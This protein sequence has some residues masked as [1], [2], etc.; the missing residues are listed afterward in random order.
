MSTPRRWE[1][2]PRLSE[3]H[4]ARFPELPRLLVQLLHNRGICDPQ[5]VARFLERQP[6]SDTDPFLL[7]GMHQAVERL[8]AAI[9]A[10]ER[11]VFRAGLRP[12]RTRRRNDQRR[13]CHWPR[14]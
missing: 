14:R 11:I 2:A 8:Q 9:C 7:T 13:L 5:Q 1:V 3:E 6:L 10:G 12:G 4:F